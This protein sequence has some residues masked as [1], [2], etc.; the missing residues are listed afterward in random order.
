MN[1]ITLSRSQL[2]V[3]LHIIPI[4]ALTL[5]SSIY[6]ASMSART[7]PTTAI[8]R[9]WPFEFSIS[10]D[11]GSYEQS[12]YNEVLINL[13]LRNISNN[14]VWAHWSSY[15][16]GNDPFDILISDSNGTNIYQLTK[17]IYRYGSTFEI[18][19]RPNDQHDCFYAWKQYWIIGANSPVL[20]QKGTC[21]IRANTYGPER[22]KIDGVEQQITQLETPTLSFT[23][24]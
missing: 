19:L 1:K 20:V 16:L 6:L 21:Y 9:S 11:K 23:I 12:P 10:I 15:T 2:I 5:S 4:F 22:M 24:K 18:T 3:L 8:V 13:T 7:A 17:Y 14:T